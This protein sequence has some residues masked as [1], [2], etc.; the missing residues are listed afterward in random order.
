[1]VRLFRVSIP[2]GTLVLLLFEAVLVPSSFIAA[3]YL[4]LESDPYL[5]IFDEGG[6]W[7]ILIAT[8]TVLISMHFHDLYT[9]VHIKSRILLLQQL[10]LTMG[11][12]FL[13]MGLLSY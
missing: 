12:A 5:F 13:T 6:I 1:M 8:A 9:N 7:R 3:T 4:V 11:L 2:A 10:S